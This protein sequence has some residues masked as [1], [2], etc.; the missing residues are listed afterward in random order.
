MLRGLLYDR[1][2]GEFLAR[3]PDGTVVELGAGL[4]T[5]FERIDNGKARWVDVDLPDAIAL[6]QSHFAATPRRTFLAASVLDAD[7]PAAV[8]RAASAASQSGDRL[9][10]VVE[11]AVACG[12]N[13]LGASGWAVFAPAEG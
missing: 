2:V 5:R 12:G 13:R 6:R 9:A 7:W 11:L 10:V 1:W 4:S 8:T 3:H